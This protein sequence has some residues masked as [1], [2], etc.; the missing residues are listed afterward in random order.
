MTTRA[1]VEVVNR[2]EVADGKVEI[3]DLEDRPATGQS[4]EFRFLEEKVAECSSEF[5]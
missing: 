3:G 1:N 2:R 4:L 5:G